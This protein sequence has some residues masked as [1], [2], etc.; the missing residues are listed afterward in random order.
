M[1]ARMFAHDQ[2]CLLHADTFGRHDLVGL[3]ILQ[4]AVLMDAALMRKS[5]PANNGLV[6]LHR[7][8][9]HGRDEL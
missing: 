5:I 9:G 4:H 2:R 1:A 7:E 8:R 6:I 3:R